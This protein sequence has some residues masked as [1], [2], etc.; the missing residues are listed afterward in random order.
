ML[1]FITLIMTGCFAIGIGSQLS[2]SITIRL[3]N[4]AYYMHQ[5]PEVRL[6]DAKKAFALL[7]VIRRSTQVTESIGSGQFA[8]PCTVFIVDRRV[9]TAKL[10]L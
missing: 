1:L 7:I 4:V 8:A 2:A 6:I 9:V 10:A 5:I 3:G